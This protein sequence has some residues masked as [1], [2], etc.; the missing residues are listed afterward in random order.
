MRTLLTLLLFLLISFNTVKAQTPDWSTFIAPILYQN[1]AS[2]HH[3]GGIGPFPLISYAD[4]FNNAQEIMDRVVSRE[5]PPWPA[6]PSYRRF[7]YE[8]LL[9]T[10][11]IDAI[12]SW[13]Q[14]GMP[15]GDTLLAPVP[16]VFLPGGSLLDT[17][18][19][20]I[21]IQPYTITT[22]NEVY[23]WFAFHSP[24]TDTIYVNQIEV[25][26]GLPHLVHHAD[27]HYD[28]TGTSFYNDSI[29]PTPGFSG[30]FISNYYMNAWQPGG[31][32]AKYP[33]DWG[34]MVPPGAD[35]V[36]E[37][38][39]GPG[40]MGQTDTTKMNL[41]FITNPINVREIRVGW[42]LN[43]PIPA[44]GPLVIPPDTVIY[45][46]QMSG[47]MPVDRSFISICPHM[48]LLGESYK[49]W[50]KTPANDSVPLI[51]IPHWDFH[52]QKYY[53]FPQIQKIPVGSRIYAKA[54]FDNTVNNP[55]NPNNPPQTVYAGPLT[56][57]EM[58]MTYFIYA[59]YQPGDENIVMDSTLVTSSP[60]PDATDENTNLVIYPNPGS[61][62][63]HFKARL[64]DHEKVLVD[65]YSSDGKSVLSGSVTGEELRNGLDISSV[66]N[67]I[68]IVKIQG[69]SVVHQGRMI[70]L[71]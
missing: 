16:P 38:H 25:I 15:I 51:N 56:T 44:Q 23:R 28:L 1:C 7:A 3:S 64:T 57:D 19:H 70:K 67:G 29:T 62:K 68:Y 71:R 31:G 26:P 40:G 6:D 18:H 35:F 13:V 11:E 61:G 22:N 12:V 37:I 52:W 4:A 24:F 8:A 54:S 30:G 69:E 43:N 39:Y 33:P 58:L 47:V 65:I 21:Q 50:F 42:L 41:R 27:I 59:T 2:C 32:I 48:H 53:T 49:V 14:G 60:S 36:F 10:S 63:I 46:D 20:T 9:D 5:M 66:P 55:H 34:I 17:I 45:F